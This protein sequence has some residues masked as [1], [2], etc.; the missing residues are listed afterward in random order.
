M[1]LELKNKR[2]YIHTLGCKVN[3]Y[4]SDAMMQSLID[5]GCVRGSLEEG[6]DIYIIN[7]CSVTNIADR[8]SR[9]MIHRMRK[10]SPNSIIAATGCYVQATGNELVDNGTCDLI[11]G[12][13]RKKDTARIL[14]EYIVNKSTTDNY[15]DI[16][17]DPD[18]ENLSI[19]FPEN[20][21]RAYIKIQD[22]C[23]NFCTYCIIPYVRGRIRSRKLSNIIEEAALLADNG[24]KELVLTGINVSSYRDDSYE[25]D[26]TSDKDHYD[27]ADVISE[28]AKIDGIERIRMSSVE[29]RVITDRFL[30]VVVNTPKFCPHFH[31][32]LQSAS[33]NTLKAMN[34][35]YTIEEY[36]DTVERLRSVYDRPAITTDVIVGFPGETEEDFEDTFNNLSKLSLYEIHTFKYSRRKGT[37]ADKMPNQV[38]EQI[39]NERSE[40]ILSLTAAQK[41]SYED[42]FKNEKDTI[43]IEEIIEKDGIKYYRGHTTRYILVD[44]PVTSVPSD[45]DENKLINTLLEISL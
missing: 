11:I 34:R 40:K 10:L 30:D 42:S 39:K 25:A 16:N 38:E 21:T 31:L 22:G 27:L 41:K 36:M 2:V 26:D 14:S 7:T 13:N 23:N 9:Q 44:V 15:I 5:E 28:V 37:V 8:K 18:F 12:N 45:S 4:E 6:A 32:S 29:P 24:V 43:L 35:H 19:A 33:N 3:Q 20:H 1:S 17:A